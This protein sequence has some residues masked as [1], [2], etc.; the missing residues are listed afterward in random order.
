MNMD[1]DHTEL[2]GNDATVSS[3]DA[4]TLNDDAE[5]E[6]HLKTEQHVP[7]DPNDPSVANLRE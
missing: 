1:W 4:G 3:P 6:V 2:P 7:V 5:Y